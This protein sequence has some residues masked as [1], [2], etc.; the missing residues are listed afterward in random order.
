MKRECILL[1]RLSRD[2]LKADSFDRATIVL[3]SDPSL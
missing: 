1:N 2:I 3:L